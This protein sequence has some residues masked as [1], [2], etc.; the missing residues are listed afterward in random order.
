MRGVT[1]ASPLFAFI[2]PAACPTCGA[3]FNLNSGVNVNDKAFLS[4]FPYAA[5]PWQGYES[6]PHANLAQ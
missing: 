4:T 6:V 2:N 5:T 3:V 1:P